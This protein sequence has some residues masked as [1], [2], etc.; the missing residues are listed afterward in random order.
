MEWHGTR[1]AGPDTPQG[2]RR[3]VFCGGDTGLT[4]AG[5]GVH[6]TCNTEFWSRKAA[7]MCAKCGDMRA[8]PSLV[9]AACAP[10]S[11]YRNY[12]KIR[13]AQPCWHCGG[14][15]GPGERFRHDA[16]RAEHGRRKRA[17]LCVMCGSANAVHGSNWCAECLDDG[18]PQYR[19]YPGVCGGP[20]RRA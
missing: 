20:A 18:N 8:G 13:G 10:G 1:M 5:G 19:D 16:C 12:A 14:A 7:G 9:C 6:R 4:G 11:P 2:V 15:L 17:G 3:C